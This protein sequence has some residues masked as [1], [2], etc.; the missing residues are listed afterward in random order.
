[1]VWGVGKTPG[2]KPGKSVISFPVY[3]WPQSV[4]LQIGGVR[5]GAGKEALGGSFEPLN[6]GGSCQGP[7]TLAGNGSAEREAAGAA[8]PHAGVLES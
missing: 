4:H 1:M 7:L 5:V 2:L 6:L 8:L 3:L